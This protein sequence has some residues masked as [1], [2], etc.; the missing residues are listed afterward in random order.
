[1]C[2]NK[3]I[4][5]CHFCHRRIFFADDKFRISHFVFNVPHTWQWPM[6][7]DICT[8]SI[9]RCIC[10][11]NRSVNVRDAPKIL[12]Y[13]VWFLKFF[14]QFSEKIFV[15]IKNEEFFLFDIYVALFNAKY[16]QYLKNNAIAVDGYSVCV[17]T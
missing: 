17:E 5:E 14:A 1:M 16:G 8:V 4:Y 3:C 11:T 9:E 10:S 2:S 6:L 12:L 7:L 15:I 13:V